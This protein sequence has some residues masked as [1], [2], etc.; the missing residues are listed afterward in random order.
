VTRKVAVVPGDGIGQEVMEQ[1]V[2]L[3]DA[4]EERK[5]LGVTLVHRDWGAE[6]WLRE[7]VGLPD[8]ALEELRRDFTAILF[9]ALGDPRIP[10]M[11]HARQILL[12]LRFGLDLYVNRRPVDL[13]HPSLCPL[14]GITELDLVVLREN[15]EGLY[16]GVGGVFKQ[17]TADEVAQDVEINTRKG[18]ERLLRHAFEVARTRR[19]KLCMVDKHNA[20]PFGGG[21]WQRTY[22]ALKGEYPDVEAT[23]LLA[24]MAAHEL[25]RNP[26]RF[27]VVVTGNLLG[28]I[29][30]DLGAALVGGLGVAPSANLN[31]GGLSLYEPVHGSAPD[32]VGRDLANPLAAFLTVGMMLAD[33]GHGD[34]AQAIRRAA[35]TCVEGGET[36][37]DLG[38]RLGTRAMGDAFLR[39]VLEDGARSPGA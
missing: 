29:L 37:P 5:R 33:L 25:V 20:V 21:L 3:L 17:D 28:D 30:T 16:A 12:G 7:G 27:D 23:H 11:A 9:G 32:L 15:T 22:K 34:L 31:P 4:L 1:A 14:K 2:R 6:R 13:L 26:R 39:H 19:R 8:G 10:D 35:V 18:V 36:T 24:D 38:G